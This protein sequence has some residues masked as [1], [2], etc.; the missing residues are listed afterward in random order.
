MHRAKEEFVT[1]QNAFRFI[2]ID[3]DYFKPV[4]LDPMTFTLTLDIPARKLGKIVG[5]AL[6]LPWGEGDAPRVQV[7]GREVTIERGLVVR[8]KPGNK[9]LCSNIN[10]QITLSAVFN[11]MQQHIVRNQSLS[12]AEVLAVN[13]TQQNNHRKNNR[14]QES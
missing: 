3:P 6:L 2:S 11:I 4:F 13:I 7:V 5:F 12:E 1:E 8:A 14:L 9:S 10:P